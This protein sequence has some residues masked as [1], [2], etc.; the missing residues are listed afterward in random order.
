MDELHIPNESRVG[1]KLSD[2]TTKRV[3][4]L[5]LV[6]LLILP[7]FEADFYIDP[8][9]SWDLSADALDSFE[10][11]PGYEDVIDVIKD[12]HDE[13]VRRPVI[14]ISRDL[15]DDET[16]S[17]EDTEPDDLRTTEKYYGTSGDFVVIADLREDTRL[18]AGLNIAKTWFVCIVLAVGALTFNQD[19]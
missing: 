19:A 1:K 5:V 8:Y 2:L 13:D 6:M 15:G 12:Y 18:E 3:I 11:D 16:W 4:L 7:L 17:W 14:K 10:D 9:K